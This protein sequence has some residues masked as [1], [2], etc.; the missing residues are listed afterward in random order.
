M[1]HAI[2]VRGKLNKCAE[3]HDADNFTCVDHTRLNICHDVPDGSDGLIDH[4]LIS[5][6]DI[7]CAVVCDVNLNAC[8]LDDLVDDLTLL[9]DYIADLRRIDGDLCDL[10]SVL[11][12]SLSRLADNR[13]P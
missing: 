4:L 2:L 10:R 11:G 6:A 7:D 5:T 1:N 9:A 3:F 13:E 12:Q 8:L